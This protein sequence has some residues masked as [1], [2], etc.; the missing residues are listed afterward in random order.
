MLLSNVSFKVTLDGAVVTI[1]SPGIEFNFSKTLK[2]HYNGWSRPDSYVTE[3]GDTTA[4]PGG[5]PSNSNDASVLVYL[6]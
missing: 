2:I 3:T 5:K 1:I 4:N 6:V